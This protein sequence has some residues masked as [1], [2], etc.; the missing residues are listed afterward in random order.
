MHGSKAV[1][2]MLGFSRLY[3][4]T[5][6]MCKPTMSFEIVCMFV[7]EPYTLAYIGIILSKI[8]IHFKIIHCY[9]TV[10]IF[11]NFRLNLKN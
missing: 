9:H 4:Y 10:V 5:H 11:R 8:A 1:A 7:K 6:Y 2:N 3:A